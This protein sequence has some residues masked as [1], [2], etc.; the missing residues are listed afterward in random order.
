MFH[1]KDLQDMLLSRKKGQNINSSQHAICVNILKSI[2]I[3]IDTC[4]KISWRIGNYTKD[5]CS[6]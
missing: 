5:I 1:V 2:Y 6:V 3:Y 4:I